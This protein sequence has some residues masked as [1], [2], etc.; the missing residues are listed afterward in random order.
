[1]TQLN[2][3]QKEA[4][5]HVDGPLLVIAGAGSGKTRVVTY[6]VARLLEIGILPT[7][8][9]AVTFTN[10]AAEVMKKRI[11]DLQ[12]KEILSCTFHSLGARILRE[13]I[14]T[15]GYRSDFTIYD[16]EDSEN[17]VK[18]CIE[19]M[20][21]KEEKGIV[22]SIK[23][24]ISSSKNDLLSPS[25]AKATSPNER[26]L[27]DMYSLYQA[28]L[29]EAN[30]VD[31]DDLLYLSVKL[32]QENE[33][34][35]TEYQNRWLFVLIDEYQD[36]N[37]AQYTLA[38]LLVEKHRNIFAVGDPDQSIYS[39]RGARYQ[40]ILNFKSDFPG[41]K[42]ITLEQN[43]R[44]TSVILN[45]ANALIAHNTSRYEKNLWST[46]EKGDK[47]G[48]F[49]APT[50]RKEAEFVLQK[51]SQHHFDEHQTLEEI[52]IFYRTNAQ[53]RALEDI[54]LS[55]RIPYQI[56]GGLSFY[57]RR[58]IKD[59]LGFLR[60]A[61]SGADFLSFTRTIYIPKRG[62]GATTVKKILE[63]A[64]EKQTP[65]LSFCEELVTYPEKNPDC[66]LSQRQKEGLKEYL[67]LI[68]KLRELIATEPNISHF[69]SDVVHMTG[70]L[71]H[72]REDPETFEDRRDNIEALISK[73]AEWEMETEKPSLSSFLEELSLKSHR[74]E[75]EGPAIKLMTLHNGKGLEFELV[76]V[77]G[78]EE[79][80]LPHG[81][82]KDDP[83]ALEEERRLLYVGMTRAKK[84]LY[85]SAAYSRLLWGAP[86]P[87]QPSRFFKEIPSEF[88]KNFSAVQR[89][90][91]DSAPA[92][93][94]LFAPGE[95]VAHQEFGVGVV[96]KTYHTSYGPTYDVFF[97]DARTTRSLIAKYAKLKPAF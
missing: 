45:A 15:L 43:Y 53:S 78:L 64:S 90:E 31:F 30:A 94:F 75:K 52:A 97:E 66:K 40:N 71:Q 38:R 39:W 24:F 32:L 68:R 54:F 4:V 50:E 46:I 26:F 2:P 74:D 51:I 36:T 85:L 88:L 20:P 95:K 56:I 83:A 11:R 37:L 21:E 18:S 12:G 89:E 14:S 3:Q 62:L 80:L 8:I 87:M 67:T 84:N 48:V 29:K 86:R 72:L 55:R 92:E 16:E 19:S 70:Y 60:M 25:D 28:K 76:F 73:A 34:A 9:L 77:V 96:Q 5:E 93:D 58:E 7:D 6:R 47:I 17:V 59:L 69:L 79:G 49:F 57:Q 35:R 23:L 10:K 82:S 65:I 91:E 42:V 81:N 22:K 41:A 44:S 27:S 33:K 61:L 1:M 63:V 13:S